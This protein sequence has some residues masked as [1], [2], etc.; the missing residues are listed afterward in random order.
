MSDNE[1]QLELYYHGRTL[2]SQGNVVEAIVALNKSLLIASHFKTCELLGRCYEAVGDNVNAARH[3]EM[4]V[5]QN[6]RS[7][8][9]AVLLANVLLRLGETAR[10]EEL[11]VQ[12]L[13]RSPTYGPARVLLQRLRDLD[14]TPD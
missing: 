8:N 3:Y 10:S 9:T 7:N 2:F 13:S 14:R 6:R 5:A 4:G 11:V 12:V 1:T